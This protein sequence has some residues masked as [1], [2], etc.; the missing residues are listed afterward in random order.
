MSHQSRVFRAP[1]DLLARSAAVLNA[2]LADSSAK[3]II[4][5]RYLGYSCSH[6]VRQIVYLNTYRDLLISRGVRVIAISTDPTE[7][8][9]QLVVSQDI[10]SNLFE[11]VSDPE[12]AIARSICARRIENDSLFDLH[13]AIVRVGASITY[14]SFGIEPDMDVARIVGSIPQ[15]SQAVPAAVEPE[16]IDRYLK[17]QPTT[18]IIAGPSEGVVEPLDLDFNR[19][20]LHTDDLWVVTSGKRGHGMTIIH[21]A[22][23]SKPAL[24]NKQDSRANHFMWRTMALAMG[25]NGG[26]GTAQNGEPGDGDLDYMFMGPTLWSSDTAVFA[27]RYQGDNAYLGS[28]VDMLHQSPFDLGM[29]HDSAN[30]YWVSDAKYLGISRYDFRDPHEVGGS[31]HRDGVIRRYVETQIKAGERGR[32]AHIALDKSSGY[33]Y[34]IDPGNGAVHCLDTKSGSVADTLVMPPSSS[35][36]V[37]EFTSVTGTDIW[38]VIPSLSKP[39]GIEVTGRRLLVGDAQTAR[40]HIYA[41]EG[42]TLNPLGYIQTGAQSLHGIVVGPDQRIWFVDKAAGTVCRLDLGTHN[43]LAATRRV[44]VRKQADTMSFQYTNAGNTTYQ[45]AYQTRVWI[46]STGSWTPWKRALG[47]KIPSGSA[48]PLVVDL[49]LADST[50]TCIVEIA[51]IDSKGVLGITANCYVVPQRTRKVIVND[52]R[53]GTFDITEAVGQTTRTGYATI[54]SELFLEIASELPY[55]KTVLWNAGTGG[56]IS[57]VDDAVLRTCIA[58]NVDVMMIGDDPF[59]LRTDM[60]QSVQFFREFGASMR[61]VQLPENDNGLRRYA[62]VLADPVTSGIGMIECELPRFDHHRGLK[63]MPSVLFNLAGGSSMMRNADDSGHVGIR[64]QKGTYRSII[65]GINASRFLDGFQRTVILDKGLAWLE[66][67]ADSDPIDTTTSVDE[68]TMSSNESIRLS[69]YASGR[70]LHWSV[71]RESMANMT[72]ELYASTGQK[73]TEIYAGAQPNPTGTIELQHVSSGCYHII[74]RSDELILHRP[75]IIR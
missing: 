2:S 73:I 71:V 55:L 1:S 26:M 23:S 68:P 20:A 17:Q 7:R 69:A 72:V 66:G 18:T 32:P 65:L 12:G 37:E 61:G 45:P 51:E 50:S 14:A 58:R 35:E 41:I 28:H 49:D 75:I 3:A 47:P 60:P 33:L 39:I 42:K 70:T 4:I 6:C 52:E 13:A 67:A 43:V 16:F 57:A 21:N 22:T 5:V 63:H 40:I 53:I 8:W 24:V 64:Y 27:S 19:S 15:S 62:G 30:V 59:L 25:D 44:I 46:A 34:Y 11:Y 9:K 29:A 31:D 38:T 10:D 74:V 54:A 56:E 36:N 48:A